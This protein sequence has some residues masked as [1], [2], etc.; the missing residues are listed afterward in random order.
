[1][2]VAGSVNSNG[3]WVEATSLARAIETELIAQE[4]V[5]PAEE[6]EDALLTRRKGLVALSRGIVTYLTANLDVVLNTGDLRNTG[7]SGGQVPATQKSFTVSSN[8]IVINAGALRGASDSGV[9]VPLATKT[10]AGKVR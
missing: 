10:L 5:D 3:D 2:L 8:Q 1:M 6:T 7:E 4:L 9:R